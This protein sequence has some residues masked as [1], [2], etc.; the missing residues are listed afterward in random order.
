MSISGKTGIDWQA[1]RAALGDVESLDTPSIVKRRSRDFFWYSPILNRQLAR[2]FGDLVAVPKNGH[3]LRRC[4]STAVE[5]NVPVV[6]RGGGTGN[7]GQAVPL[8]GGLIVDMTAMNRILEIGEDFVRVEAGCKIGVLNAALRQE[9]RELPIFPSTMEL[10]TIGGFIAGGSAGIGSIAHGMLR[11]PGNI[12][13]ITVLSMEARPREC[14]FE[15]DDVNVV[16]HAWGLNGIIT[17]LTLPT[18]PARDWINVVASFPDYREA[19]EAGA[20]LGSQASFRP[21]LVTTIDGRIAAYIQRLEQVAG[22]G[23]AL[24]LA[25]VS[26]E[27]VEELRRIVEA[28]GG[29]QD[30]ALDDRA[31]KEA[32]LPLVFEF[33]YNH[34]TLL[35][36]KANRDVTYLQAIFPAPLDPRTVD[37]LQLRFGDEVLMHHEFALLNGNLVAID[38]PIVRYTTDERLY[39]IIGIYEAHGC[40]VSDPHKFVV[41][42]GSLKPDFRHLAWKKRLDPA[43]L[44]NPGKSQAWPG[45]RHLT[46]DEIEALTKDRP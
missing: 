41:E 40:P 30:L 27:D 35:V 34:T 39:E 15:G 8:E 31:M 33:S 37:A 23:R 20:A 28:H 13:S 46:A 14:V 3:E 12:V 17:E 25:L 7:Y 45:I 29:R 16:H 26:K 32:G 5:W 10:A 22:S 21:K 19:F 9:G 36:L 6:V 44:L 11:D 24:L 43:G 42:G 38:L 4:I 1:F 18:V 2:S